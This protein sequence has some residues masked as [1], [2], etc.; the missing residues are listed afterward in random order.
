MT[1]IIY[2]PSLTWC[3]FSC[4]Y[5]PFHGSGASADS[6]ESDF[7]RDRA[8]LAR[9]LEWV[10]MLALPV[11]LL[12]APRG[13]L[14][15]L[16]HYREAALKLCGHPMVERLVIQTNLSC[17]TDWLQEADRTS[18]ALWVT[19]HPGQQPLEQ[20]L[21]KCRTIHTMAITFSLGIVGVRE[22]LAPARA[23][24]KA[25]PPA[26][27]LWVNAYKDEP[28]YYDVE[29]INAFKEI[30]PL[31]EYNLTDYPSL[32]QRCRAGVD[33]FYVMGD[34]TVRRCF[35]S[36]AVLGNIY[37]GKFNI[38][39]EGGRELHICAEELCICYLGYTRLAG[40]P[41]EELY[42][43]RVLERVWKKG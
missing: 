4:P 41:W 31:F 43:D 18:L 13:E 9:F 21:V 27:Y 8:E 16:P 26:C 3:S 5:C 22:N 28:R 30:D 23:L 29:L 12:F 34:G 38:C 39:P 25:L 32:G 42:G 35:F 19:A 10:E 11:R 2:R 37:S 14:L 7:S 15:A 17:D 33:T 20:L 1:T 6:G 24:R 40:Q 36:A